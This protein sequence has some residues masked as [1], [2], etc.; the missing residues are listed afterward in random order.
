[1]KWCDAVRESPVGMAVRLLTDGREREG[2]ESNVV[3]LDEKHRPPRHKAFRA[4]EHCAWERRPL[5]EAGA[6][7]DWKPAQDRLVPELPGSEE[8]DQWPR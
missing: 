2:K 7:T 4:V 5:R 1:V 6:L 8:Q 3:L